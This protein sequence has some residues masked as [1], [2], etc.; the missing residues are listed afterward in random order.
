M[1]VKTFA[2]LS[3]LC[4]LS[5]SVAH[6][7]DGAID[8]TFGTSGFATAGI[9]NVVPGPPRP[10][11]IVQPDGKILI[12]G[13]VD[14]GVPNGFDMMVVRFNSDGSLDTS[15]SF[16]GR[17]TVSFADSTGFDQCT[18][19]ALQSDGKII[20]AGSTQASGDRQHFAIARFNAD[21]SLDTTSFGAGTGKITVSF[22]FRNDYAN[23][24]ALQT[25][26]KIVLA[27]ATTNIAISG[28]NRNF[29]IV[30]LNTDGT[31]DSTFNS[32]GM[33]I[34]AFDLPVSGG[35][36]AD[37]A[38]AIAIDSQNRIVVAGSAEGVSNDTDFAV[39]R[40]L[41]NGQLDTSFNS[42]CRQV[43]PFNIAGNNS[44]SAETL[45]VLH[46]DKIVLAGAQAVMLDQ[47]RSIWHWCDCNLMVL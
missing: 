19:L 13:T 10:G 33:Q 22:G 9:S 17:T 41:S 27:G 40:L 2:S 37:T 47:T 45:L 31:L 7:T 25:D 46:D 29:A 24:L 28:S 3:A 8:T 35:T 6:A 4:F 1:L 15:F 30:R 21:G 16:D 34:V 12:A 18:A 39:A 20:V 11:P 36:L 32:T 38:N 44:D 14:S 43:I 42:S 23:S 5:C 26:G